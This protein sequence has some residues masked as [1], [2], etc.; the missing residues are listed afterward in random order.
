MIRK[1]IIVVLTLG[2]AGT[3]ALRAVAG[4]TYVFRSSPELLGARCFFGSDSEKVGIGCVYWNQFPE[5]PDWL[6]E[7]TRVSAAFR[8]PQE[9]KTFTYVRRDVK[10]HRDSPALFG[11][12]RCVY[13][14]VPFWFPFVLFAAY[15]ALAFLRGPLR[16]YRRRKR[17]LCVRCGYNL[18]GLTE[19]R[20]PEC[21]RSI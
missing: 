9:I 14:V 6:E 19:S 16:R 20:C 3:V 2:A 18:T 13:L 12:V 8:W 17:G 10:G 15:P 4:W 21:G 7:F 1:T 5:R 11:P